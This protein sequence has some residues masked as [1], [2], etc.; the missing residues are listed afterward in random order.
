MVD[1]CE[2]FL[3]RWMEGWGRGRGEEGRGG[4]GRGREVDFRSVIGD[5]ER[6]DAS[7][8]TGAGTRTY[9]R[10]SEEC[11]QAPEE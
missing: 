2:E 7:S 8:C 6:D 9:T 5:T 10:H 4:E 1:H 3:L 11:P